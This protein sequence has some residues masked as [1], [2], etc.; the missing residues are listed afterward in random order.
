[1]TRRFGVFL[2][3][4]ML[5]SVSADAQ[6]VGSTSM[7]FLEVMPVARATALGDAYSV[8]ATGAD[9][10]F[11]NPSGLAVIEH[12]ELS[13]TFVKWIFDTRQ[14]ALS[15][16]TPLGALGAVG[17]QIQYVDY[18]E[19]EE[20]VA[21]RPYIDQ[22]ENQGLTGN[23]FHPFSYLVG[24][25]YA[26]SLTDKFST[27]LSV[28]FAHE[29]LYNGQMV[30]A[31]VSPIAT[32]EVKTWASGVMFDFGMRYN[33][34]Y[35]TV[36]IGASVQ[37]FGPNV[38]YAIQ[39]SP[40]PL[41]FRWGIAADVIGKDALL[42]EDG[43]NRV[44]IAFDLYQPNDYAQQEHLG[45][46]YEYAGVLALRVGY[47]FNYDYEGLTLGAGVQQPIGSVLLAF[48]YSYGSIGP[49]LG[50]VQRISL[51]ARIQ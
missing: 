44:G 24:L 7:E 21:T 42:L 15:Y 31:Q 51:G 26:R 35:H 25:S 19:F 2:A 39:S 10:V 28:K 49:Y 16:A 46:E 13:S 40:V 1:M 47:K 23:T 36:Q 37:N 43:E 41:L 27:G 4:M 32:E 11:W 48:D 22:I 18:G 8:W 33:T 50:N 6:K 9:A 12:Q 29:S 14:G 38:T 5:A 3:A 20:A 45:V 17:L 30:L 34:G